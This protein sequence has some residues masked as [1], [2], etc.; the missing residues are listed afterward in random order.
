MVLS[1]SLSLTVEMEKVKMLVVNF[2][3]IDDLLL[4]LSGM[5]EW[6]FA[7]SSSAAL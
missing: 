3:S 5:D 4:L 6:Y 2:W 1:V 7:P